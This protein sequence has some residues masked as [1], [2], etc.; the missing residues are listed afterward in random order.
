MLCRVAAAKRLPVHHHSTD[1][2]FSDPLGSF[3]SFWV[4]LKIEF[5]WI[6]CLGAGG[7]GGRVDGGR[8]CSI[9]F[10]H[11]NRLNKT[12]SALFV[13]LMLSLFP[14]DLHS[15]LILWDQNIIWWNGMKHFHGKRLCHFQFWRPSRYTVELQWLEH[16]RLVY[17]GCFE[18][19]LDSL[20][21]IP[22]RQTKDN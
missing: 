22:Q 6:R 11:M 5:R 13:S 16:W 9:L 1:Y 18:H 8:C 14:K 10:L 19:V 21:K 17:H 20:G 12:E 7:G 4:S 3:G 15:D 2:M